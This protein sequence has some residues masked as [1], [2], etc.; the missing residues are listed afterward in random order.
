MTVKVRRYKRGGWEVDI[1][2]LLANGRDLRERRKAPVSTKDQALRWG[3][4]RERVLLLQPSDQLE[5]KEVSKLEVFSREFMATYARTNNKPSELSSKRTHLDLHILP[6]LGERRLDEI[7][8]R[9]VER[10]KAAMLDKGLKPKSVNNSL[11]VLGKILRYAVEIEEIDVVPK[12]RF[13]KLPPQDF[14]FLG[15]D[16][17]SRLLDGAEEHWRP[18]VR[19][20]LRTGLRLGELRALRWDDVD[21]VKGLLRVRQ[22][23]WKNKVGSPKGG[24]GRDIPLSPRTMVALKRHSRFRREYVFTSKD[25]TMLTEGQCRWPLRRACRQAGLRQIGWH[26]LRHSFASHLVMRG[27]P[28][29]T[30]QELLGH[31][32]IRMTMRYAH[33]APEVK[34]D[35][36]RL[37]DG[38]VN[39]PA[40]GD[41]L[42]TANAS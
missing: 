1:R 13:L 11:A 5:R 8:A 24:R 26:V 3:R 31:S 14:D 23:A 7:K 29:K 27:V 42:E 16:E 32:D 40:V 12:I 34:D 37:L 25:G 22:A 20:A 15:F 28:L 41:I 36:V 9:Q 10:F 4:E 17:A 6:L 35:A 19:L 39:G 2:I 21:L 30:V 38:P 18:M 33:L